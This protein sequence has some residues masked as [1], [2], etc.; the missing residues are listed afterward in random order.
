MNTYR[1]GKTENKGNVGTNLFLAKAEAP[2]RNH[3]IFAV[4]KVG[5][6]N[7]KFLTSKEI[8]IALVVVVVAYFRCCLLWL[9]R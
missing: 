4:T 1:Y 9:D 6:S 3:E 5:G 8:K 2:G 7:A